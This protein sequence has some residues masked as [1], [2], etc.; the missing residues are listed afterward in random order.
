[1][2]AR[3]LVLVALIGCH[4]AKAPPPAT[5]HVDDDCVLMCGCC[6]CS[7]AIAR[8]SLKDCTQDE[9]AACLAGPLVHAVARCREGACVAVAPP[10]P[11]VPQPIDLSTFSRSCGSDADCR[12]VDNEP[13]SSCSCADN[14]IASSET[15][16]FASVQPDCR[17]RKDHVIEIRIAPCSDCPALVAACERGTCIAKPAPSEAAGEC[18]SD[19]D[20]IVSCDSRDR[21]CPE[22]PCESVQPRARAAAIAAYNQGRCPAGMIAACPAVVAT[23]VVPR[24]RDGRCLAQFPRH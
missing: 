16:Q 24:C 2:I 7:T 4:R 3:V 15:S 14:A 23:G 22:V 13:C 11:P 6:P 8:A 17:T 19:A 5:C 20:C 18:R 21:C 12:L 1:V 9:V 10:P